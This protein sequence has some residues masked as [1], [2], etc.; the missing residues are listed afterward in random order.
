MRLAFPLRRGNETVADACARAIQTGMVFREIVQANE[1]GFYPS[2]SINGF[3]YKI[4]RFQT[5]S[6]VSGHLYI[7]DE[8]NHC[9]TATSTN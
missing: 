1:N 9:S 3:A 4:D 7:M 2:G 8:I 5:K 6:P